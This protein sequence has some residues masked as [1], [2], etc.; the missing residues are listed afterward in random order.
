MARDLLE[1]GTTTSSEASIEADRSCILRELELP[2]LT[3][4]TRQ[5]KEETVLI[6]GSAIGRR[7]QPLEPHSGN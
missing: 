1:E 7:P 5:S 2:G 3:P 6:L 4:V